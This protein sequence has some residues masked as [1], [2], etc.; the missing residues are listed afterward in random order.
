MEQAHVIEPS[1]A[2][3]NS[4]LSIVRKSNGSLRICADLRAL[5]KVCENF[6]WEFPRLDVALHKMTKATIFSKIDLTS[7]FWQL[8]LA[9]EAKDFTTFRIDGKS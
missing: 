7:G 5:N 6:E 4:P 8:P 9:D 2:L 3:H 1:S